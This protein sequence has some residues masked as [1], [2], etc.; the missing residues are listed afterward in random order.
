MQGLQKFHTC[1]DECVDRLAPGQ[2]CSCPLKELCLDAWVPPLVCLAVKIPR[3]CRVF[4]VLRHKIFRGKLLKALLP[5]PP[6]PRQVALLG[7]SNFKLRTANTSCATLPSNRLLNVTVN[8]KGY[9]VLTNLT[10]VKRYQAQ[11]TDRDKPDLQLSCP[12]LLAKQLGMS[13]FIVRGP[14]R[15]LHLGQRRCSHHHTWHGPVPLPCT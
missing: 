11:N 8:F 1:C 7:R 4:Q 3:S 13:I 2:G 9:H 15:A 10:A 14:L 6:L 5:H 12:V